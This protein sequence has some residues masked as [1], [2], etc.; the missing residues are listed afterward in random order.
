MH[1][2]KHHAWVFIFGGLLSLLLA[3]CAA[4]VGKTIKV[5]DEQLAKYGTLSG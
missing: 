3:G 1:A 5:S 2:Q 4:N